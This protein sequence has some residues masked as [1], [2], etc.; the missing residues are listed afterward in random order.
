MNDIKILSSDDVRR[1]VSI[2]EA[3]DAVAVSYRELS[4]GRAQMPVRTVTDFNYDDLTVFYKPAY[5]ASGH[6]AGVKL[7]SQLRMGGR[8]GHPTIQGIVMLI[9]ARNNVTQ[10][11][12]DGTYLTAL[13]TGAASG[14][15]TRLLARE[16]SHTLAIFGAG[17]QAHTQF[18]AMCAVRR[19][20]KA[21]IFDIHDGAVEKF[22]EAHEG[23]GVDLQPGG[24]I[25]K[26]READIIC[27]VTN[28]RTPLFPKEALR[29]GVHINAI[30]SYSLEMRELPD[31]IYVGTSLFVDHRASCFSESGDIIGPVSKGLLPDVSYKGEIGELLAGKIRGRDSDEEITV[32]KSVGVAVQDLV[33]AHYAYTKACSE[34]AGS[35]IT[36]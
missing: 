33:T 14:V 8:N 26:L 25:S 17:A 3:I 29:K 35:D 22:I 36:I 30:G 10:A 28:S 4:E 23:L 11:I 16:D 13:R 12:V 27:T 7:L 9:D 15:A 20:R 2:E 32:F 6:I 34:K 19:I 21:Y 24:D 1:L 18:R 31:D 5:M